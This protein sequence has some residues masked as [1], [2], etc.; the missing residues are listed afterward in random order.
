MKSSR[1]YI[2]SIFSFDLVFV[3]QF[4][5]SSFDDIQEDEEFK[6]DEFSANMETASFHEPPQRLALGGVYNHMLMFA[7]LGDAT[8]NESNK[9]FGPLAESV[10]QYFTD[11][12]G[13]KEAFL[14]AVVGRAL[15]GWVWLAVCKDGRLLITQTNNEDNPLM[16]GVV[17]VPCVPIVGIDLWEHAYLQQYGG[18]KEA[19]VDQFFKC[20]QWGIVSANFELFNSQG[21]ATPIGIDDE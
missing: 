21:N 14:K 5:T 17:D 9:P 3:Q 16:H 8:S 2:M 6:K 20:I 4:L 7:Q 11:F 19:Y 18:D 1:K 15:P 13:L 12:D 10:A